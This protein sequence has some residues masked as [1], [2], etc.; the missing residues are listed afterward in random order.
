MV[1]HECHFQLRELRP[2]KSPQCYSGLL[3]PREGIG[4]DIS[5][6]LPI[7]EVSS[8]TRAGRNQS[9][10]PWGGRSYSRQLGA[11][12]HTPL[13]GSSLHRAPQ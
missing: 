6:I 7:P 11:P 3:I 5:L 9:P 2:P 8:V 4:V 1:P 13:G 12:L 10:Q